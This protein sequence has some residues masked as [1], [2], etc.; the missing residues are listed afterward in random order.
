VKKAYEKGLNESGITL[1][2][3]MEELKID[4]K[5]MIIN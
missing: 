4:L 3:L 1:E 5:N 2:K